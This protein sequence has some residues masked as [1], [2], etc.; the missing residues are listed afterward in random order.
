MSSCRRERT[1]RQRNTT[2][3]STSSHILFGRAIFRGTG[4]C[5]HTRVPHNPHPP[6]PG[7]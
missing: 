5:R 3:D 7:K 2:P 4:L 1:S 6:M